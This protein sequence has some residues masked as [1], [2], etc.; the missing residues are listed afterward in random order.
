MWPHGLQ[1]ARASL[2]F[3]TSQSLPKFMS[4]ELVMLTISPVITLLL[5][6]VSEIRWPRWYGLLD[7]FK[8]T[9]FASVR[10]QA[11]FWP[12]PYTASLQSTAQTWN[13]WPSAGAQAAMKGCQKFCSTWPKLTPTK[14]TVEKTKTGEQTMAMPAPGRT[15]MTWGT[16]SKKTWLEAHQKGTLLLFLEAGPS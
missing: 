8:V 7:P 11:L 15:Q 9:V 2:C 10:S 3:T 4:I 6:N 5:L 14:P 16:T 12:I 1:H 13:T